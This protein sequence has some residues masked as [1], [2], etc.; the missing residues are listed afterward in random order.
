[1]RGSGQAWVIYAPLLLAVGSVPF[2]P[3]GLKMNE[4]IFLK[5]NGVVAKRRGNISG[6]AKT[7]TIFMS[8]VNA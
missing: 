5:E 4:N 2:E 3:H 7:T 1:M 6:Q 8:S